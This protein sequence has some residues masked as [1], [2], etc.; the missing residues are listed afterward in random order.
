M[1]NIEKNGI[2]DLICKTDIWTPREERGGF[3]T[4]EIGTDV[5]T[6]VC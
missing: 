4:W 5:Y 1:W 3:M 2:D 6:A